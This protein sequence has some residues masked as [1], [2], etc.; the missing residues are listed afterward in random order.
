MRFGVCLPN[1]GRDSTFE[2][3]RRTAL[4][5]E[6]LGYESV[7]T[8]DH[9]VVPEEN[10]D[11]YGRIFESLTTLGMVAM[12]T[13]RVKVG[14]SVLVLPMRNPILAAKQIAT[15][16]V[17][18]GGRMM[19]ALGVGWNEK[20]YANL[21]ADFH[22]RGR[23]LD[24]DIQLLR[25]LWSK[26]VV[27]FHGKYTNVDRGMSSPLPVQNGGPQGGSREVPIWIG[28]NGESSWRRTAQYGDGWH[29][30]GAS[31]EEMATGIKRIHEL[32]PNKTFVYSARVSIDINLNTSPTYQYR[33]N[34]RHRLAGTTSTIR[35]RLAEYAKAGVEMLALVFPDD[36]AVRMAQIEQFADEMMKEFA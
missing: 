26:Q 1:Y 5:A 28:G 27:T 11:P 16:D 9:I 7:W 34:L 24:E 25:A 21:H 12:L 14:A 8:T 20:E 32:N 29:A 17:A 22:N 36:P 35:A 3:I 2:D 18:S 33:G 13:Q 23:R 15:I 30:T 6:R 4:A 31:P 19:L 10:I